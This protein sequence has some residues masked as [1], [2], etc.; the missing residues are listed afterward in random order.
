MMKDATQFSVHIE[1]KNRLDELKVECRDI[2]LK[3]YKRPKRF[4]SNSDVIRFL[5]DEYRQEGVGK[6]RK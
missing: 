1:V 5:L 4:V 6:K 2:I 3:R